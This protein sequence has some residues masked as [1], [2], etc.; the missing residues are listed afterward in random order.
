MAFELASGA[1]GAAGSIAGGLINARATRQANNANMAMQRE[2]AQNG[3]RWRVEDAKAAGLS[4]LAALGTNVAMPSAQIVG[5]Q[6]LGNALANSSQNIANAI[7]RTQTEEERAEYLMKMTLLG[8]QIKEHDAR[9]SYYLSEAR[10]NL[11]TG[12]TMPVIQP[13]GA[14]KNV[15]DER[16]S[17]DP[18]DPAKSAGDGHP[19]FKRYNIYKN[20]GIDIPYSQEGPAEGLEGTGAIG[21]TILRNLLFRPAMWA[22][23]VEGKA[24]DKYRKALRDSPNWYQHDA[25]N[26]VTRGTR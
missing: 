14:V 11:S 20:F 17:T 3:I 23:R 9:A 6:S 13:T 22:D 10:R 26:L 1:I 21:L 15:P 2:F 18:K 25:D 24:R 12:P 16:V 19:M 7:S 5:D 8:S 4:P